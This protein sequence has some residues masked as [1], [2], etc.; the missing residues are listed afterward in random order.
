MHLDRAGEEASGGHSQQNLWT[1]CHLAKPRGESDAHKVVRTCHTW[2]W[3]VNRM[4]TMY[5]L[6]SEIHLHKDYI[7]GHH[8]TMLK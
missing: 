2:F 6:G 3:K 1:P 5:V 4:Q 8:H 7:I